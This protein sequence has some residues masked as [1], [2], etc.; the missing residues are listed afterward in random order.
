MPVRVFGYEII[1]TIDFYSRISQFSLSFNNFQVRRCMTHLKHCFHTVQTLWGSSTILRSRHISSSLLGVWKC[2][3][4]RSLVFDLLH[5][6]I[7]THKLTWGRSI[8]RGLDTF[9]K[10]RVNGPFSRSTWR[11]IEVITGTYVDL[12]IRFV[13]ISY[14]LKLI[15]KDGPHSHF[16]YKI[17]RAGCDVRKPPGML[18][19]RLAN[20]WLRTMI[21]TSANISW[22]QSLARIF[23]LKPAFRSWTRLQQ[24]FNQG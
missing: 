9:S 2:D 8:N 1:I 17:T 23:S 5:Q 20:I 13:L 7:R 12:D 15:V 24:N 22:G 16:G 19:L 3:N 4:V 11:K 21:L 6:I 14:K 10:V 18:P